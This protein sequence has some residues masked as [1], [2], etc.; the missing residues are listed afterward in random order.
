MD[1]EV[2][3]FLINRRRDLQRAEGSGEGKGKGGRTGRDDVATDGRFYHSPTS[4]SAAR[5]TV[6]SADEEPRLRRRR[7]ERSSNMSGKAVFG[8][9]RRRRV[10]LRA[11]A[12][13]TGRVPGEELSR[14]SR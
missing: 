9:R 13:L 3:S 2:G 5:P 10:D 7:R 4:L 11:K 8:R 6:R 14:V 1:P 12:S